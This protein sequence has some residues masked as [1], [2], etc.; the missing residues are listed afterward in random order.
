M[1]CAFGGGYF[2]SVVWVLGVG[3]G[4]RLIGLRLWGDLKFA[5]MRFY[6]I[7]FLWLW[8]SDWSDIFQ[9]GS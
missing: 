8:L 7:W 4:L 3:F 5:D 2:V 1:C 9:F 6:Q